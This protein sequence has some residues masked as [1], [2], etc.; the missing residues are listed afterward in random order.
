MKLQSLQ[1]PWETNLISQK[2]ISD[3]ISFKSLVVKKW[4]IWQQKSVRD[5]VC[6]VSKILKMWRTCLEVVI[7][8]STNSCPENLTVGLEYNTCLI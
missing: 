4:Q 8:E 2:K 6:S 5:F 1:I 7:A 3:S